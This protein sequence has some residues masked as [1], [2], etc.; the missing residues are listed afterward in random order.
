MPVKSYKVG[1]G[2]F[3]LGSVGTAQNVTPQVTTAAVDWKEDVEDAV[4]T[5][6]GEELV[7]EATYTATVSGTVVQD[8][9]TDVVGFVE[10]TWANKGSVVPFTYTPSTEVGKAV[11]GM[12][13]VKP[14]TVGGDVK[15][16]PTADFEFACIGEPTLGADLT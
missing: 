13:R 1:P 10:W 9:Q 4:P 3:S 16:R 11:T 8:L 2:T 7:G 5:L 15:K 12:C 6:S 14:L